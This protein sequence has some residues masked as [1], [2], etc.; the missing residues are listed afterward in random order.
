MAN[1]TFLDASGATK[2][3]KSTGAGSAGDPAVAHNIID[4]T[5]TVTGAG[6]T[7]PV[8][9]TVTANIGTIAGLATEVTLATATDLLVA[10]DASLDSITRAEDAIH[11]S[12]NRG[13]VSLAVRRDTL[14]GTASDGD[15]ITLSTDADG[16]LYTTSTITGSV[17]VTGTF[18]QATQ[19]VSIASTVTV[20]GTGGTF[21]VTDS[22]GTLTVDAPVGTPVFVRLSDGTNAIATLP[23]SLASVPSHAVTN[24]GT[25]VVQENGGALTALQLIDNLVLAEDAAHV[26]GD[27][28]IQSLAVRNDSDTS[29]AGTTGDYTPLQVDANG[30]LKVNIK[31][32]AGSGGTASTDDA[33]FT[34]GSGSGTPIM[35][36]VTS[37]LV[38]SGDVGVIGML[39]NR[40]V[41]VTLYDS[42]G[43]ELAV[44]GGTQYDEDTAHVS[45]DKLTMAGAVR[46]DAATSGVSAD[47]DRAT[48]NVDANG[49]LWTVVG[50]ALPA[51]TNNIGDVD[52]LTL[53]ALATGSNTIGN[54]GT[55]ATSITPGTAAANLGKAED[56]VHTT[57]DV[58][59]MALA[60]QRNTAASG[61]ADGDYATLN[62]NSTGRLYVDASVTVALPAGT[63]NIGD[64]DVL[65]L[66]ALPTGSNTIGN[67]GTIATSI[68][69][70]TAA[71]NLGKAEDAVH[72]TGDVGVLA[73]AVRR[74]AAASGVSA[75]GDNA[76]LNVDANGRLWVISNSTI[77]A[78]LPAGT[79]V[80]G[81]VGLSGRTTGGLTLHRRLSTGTDST[82]VK[83]AAG[84][85]FWGFVTNTN[86]S[87]RYI[88][89]YNSASA[90]TLGSG[91]PVLTFLVPPGSSG[92]QITAEQGLAFSTGIGYTLSTGAADADTGTVASN[93]IIVNLGYR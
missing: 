35:G 86:A 74:D 70:G 90:P 54:I 82:N 71:T 33:A 84:Q 19:P 21:P 56:A 29:L 27:A 24:A 42:A 91:T 64:V 53:P 78:A 61:A 76:T 68:T 48:M 40:Q 12:G 88:K 32:G 13:V 60:V 36:F 79:N 73:M 20:T 10:I 77:T 46:R 51:G 6:G 65:T 50:A 4:G 22:G 37:D 81:D 92:L 39:A 8:T 89:F 14:A 1:E 44:G 43:A 28:G 59:V 25:F 30:Y 7:F 11:T 15:Y 31:A 93:E 9:G 72:A 16:R 58:G 2:Y 34:A 87:A 47:G 26:S 55:I 41:K 18:W 63:N 23:V 17:A 49:L 75:D 52:V 85:L 67:I 45:G 3:R 5:V 66:P 69:P 38:D 80:I 57:G 83:N 62:V